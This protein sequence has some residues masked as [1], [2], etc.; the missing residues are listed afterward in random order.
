MI[1]LLLFIAI[2]PWVALIACT[3]IML[4]IELFKGKDR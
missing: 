4:T 2:A 3:G 1:D